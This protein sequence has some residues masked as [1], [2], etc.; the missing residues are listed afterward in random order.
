M[1]RQN[2]P[3]TAFNR[4][5]ISRLGLARTDLDRVR[6]SAET[7]T[8][9]MPRT[10]GSMML[11]P[12]LGY[13][14]A[15]SNSSSGRLI[16]F[17]AKST[18]TAL[19]EITNTK[20][21]VWIGD[22]VVT[23]GNST[24]AVTLGT[25]SS[26]LLGGWT[27]A[28]ETGSSSFWIAGNYL[29]LV[30]T[31]YSR[32]IR[33]QTVTSS[34]GTH[35]LA[36]V[37]DRGLVTFKVGS[38]AAGDDYIPEAVLR[39]GRYSFGVVST[40]NFSIEFSA[41]S[42]YASRVTSVAVESSGDLSLTAPWAAA[43]LDKLRWDASA[44][45]TFVACQG[46][47]QRRIERYS[48]ISYGIATYEPENGPFRNPNTGPTRMTASA[49]TGDITI[50][51]DKPFFSTDHVGS[52]LE[53]TSVGQQV[54]VTVTGTN[55]FSDSIRV[56]GS[57]DQRQVDVLITSSSGAFTG[58]M[59]VQRSVGEDGSFANVSGLTWTSTIDTNFNDGFSNQVMFYRIGVGST[60]TSSDGTPTGQLT[61]ASGGIT[62]VARITSST[63]S[64]TAGAAVL[65]AFGSTEPTETW[66]E[67]EWS[68]YRGYPT[69]VA[70][71]EGRL[72]WAGKAKMQLSE[73][74]AF[75]GFDNDEEGDSGPINRSIGSGPVDVI[76]WLVSL[77]RLIVGTQTRELQL[78]TSSLDDP[79]T[80]DNFSLR[81]VSGQGSN[82]V[83][84]VR[85]DRRALFVQQG[86]TRLMDLAYSGESADYD[87][88]DRTLLVP[89]M[90]EPS[91]IR[92]GVQRQP[93]TRIHC[94]RSDGTVAVLVSDAAE[95]VVCWLDVETGDADGANGVVEEV[96]VLPGSIEDSVYYIV[97]REINGSTQRFL[98]RWAMEAEAR[99][100]STNKIMDSFVTSHSS[101]AATIAS[102]ATH[103]VGETVCA[104]GSYGGG[105]DLGS[106]FV[107]S[108][109]GG[110]TGLPYASTTVFFGLPYVA[111][112]VSSKLAYAAQAGT[113]LTQKKRVNHLGLI[114]ADTHA[115]G[116]QYGA[117]TGNLDNLP[118]MEGG[119]TVSTDTVHSAYDRESVEFPGDMTTD[120]RIVLLAQSPRPCTVLGAVIQIEAK[121]KI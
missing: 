103:L 121:E 11:R 66:A 44:D 87:T 27:D 75:E 106:T 79:V 8:N 36:V 63:G 113:A 9:W 78:K 59:R 69:S 85:I 116:L 52:L 50:E 98:E 118:I 39:P 111:K 38:S 28:D 61:F 32:A 7:Q 82:N 15:I 83:Q 76:Q 107:V 102:G 72:T 105:V 13:V 54:S 95:N 90:G 108:S 51:A 43:D 42:Q 35:G 47:Q 12:G 19:F 29:G 97:R 23:R 89:E 41:N 101:T 104:W 71:H 14:G 62:G 10:L 5:R 6:L 74:D 67:G 96:A 80:P 31:K 114:L 48:T 86:G 60:F 57:T 119:E 70:L 110:I 4:G 117:S 18:D 45:V 58:T 73:S 2:A 22:S 68:D 24:A 53:M 3:I 37:V 120:S 81:D 84:A 88:V 55:Q 99:G 64:T 46:Y 109:T 1:T 20:M 65:S 94:V 93:D 26:T 91:I 16:P 34:A 17:I 40:G 92:L 115:R 56:A 21:R 100:G 30:G 25:F 112:Y 49:R 77:G 33:R